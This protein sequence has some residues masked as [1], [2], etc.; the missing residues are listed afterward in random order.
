[1]TRR[2]ALAAGVLAMEAVA[3]AVG[4]AGPASAQ[5]ATAPARAADLLRN[6]AK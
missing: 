6:P 2:D 3:S 1:M 5:A 4:T